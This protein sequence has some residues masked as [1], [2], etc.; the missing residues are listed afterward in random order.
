[1]FPAFSCRE[2]ASTYL[3]VTPVFLKFIVLLTSSYAGRKSSSL[4]G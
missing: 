3:G 1:M 2:P 4:A